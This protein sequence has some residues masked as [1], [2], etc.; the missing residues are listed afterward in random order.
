MLQTRRPGQLLCLLL[1]LGWAATWLP[2]AAYAQNAAITVSIERVGF[3]PQGNALDSAWIPVVVT[4]ENIAADTRGT[5]MVQAN[6]R[7]ALVQQPL[8]L[9]GGARK[10]LTLLYR[11]NLN[12]TVLTATFIDQQGL[13]QGQDDE[14][15]IVHDNSNALI[16]V[17]G[18]PPSALAGFRLRDRTTTVLSLAADVLPATDA[19]LANFAVIALIGI[20]PD[21]TQTAALQRWVAV[22]GVLL[23]DGG[24]SNLGVPA[25]IA[26]LAPAQSTPGT[27]QTATLA[28]FGPTRFTKPVALSVR[29]LNPRP[30][31]E[32]LAQ[33]GSNVLL[34]R[35]RVG[36]GAVIV[37]GFDVAA[38]PVDDGRNANWRSIITPA[39]MP[40]WQPALPARMINGGDASLPSFGTLALLILGYILVVGPLNYLI[41]RRL[42][43]REWAWGTIPA[44]VLLFMVVAYAAGGG[45]RGSSATALQVAVV[46]TIPG[47]DTGRVIANIGFVAGQR[48]TWTTTISRGVVVGQNRS[49][50]FSG[51]ND[52]RS[53]DIQQ[54]SD[55]TS[56]LLRWSA[57]IGE[58]RQV[59]VM[60]AAA[61]PFQIEAS[62]MG[63]TG[64]NWT[65]GTITNRG[66][67][68]IERA[69]LVAGDS[70]L[71]LPPLA[72]GDSY[73]VDPTQQLSGFPYISGADVETSIEAL[74]TLYDATQRFDNSGTLIATTLF[75]APR[76][77]I[78]T[79]HAAVPSILE[80][81]TASNQVTIYN[82]Y[83]AV[84]NN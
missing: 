57:N 68:T 13:T 12:Q 52:D 73:T 18:G 55:G 62:T 15:L 1:A 30:D 9:P 39:A 71:Q 64:N 36:L 23:V 35:Q 3:E 76:L 66:S 54:N 17:F 59:E 42:D 28:A 72:P 67:A 60:G 84:E 69:Y 65:N 83:L 4:V 2:V 7:S 38:L 29:P 63:V 27:A 14:R 50:N 81:S 32:I 75:D 77:I 74:T 70:Y 53:P 48:G 6:G 37:T 79:Q 11:A 5:L 49:F 45:L 78:I 80:R 19:E 44:G 34:V 56:V 26:Q 33:D 41:L 82:V 58:T 10:Q 22:G 24:P 61:V 25:G 20:D 16:G 8:E 21:A 46:D 43:R 47:L 51:Q 31:A 40:L